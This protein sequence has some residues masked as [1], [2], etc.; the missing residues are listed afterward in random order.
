[1]FD[2]TRWLNATPTQLS[3]GLGSRSCAS[4]KVADRL[5][6]TFFYQLIST[7]R[8]STAAGHDFELSPERNVRWFAT[9]AHPPDLRVR[10][11]PRT[12]AQ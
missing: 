5:M 6:Y 10:L 9:L 8:I 2:H 1:M 12:V 7:F 3:F 4:S 11:T